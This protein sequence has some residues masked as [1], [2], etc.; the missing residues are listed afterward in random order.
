MAE[1]QPAKAI[2]LAEELSY[3]PHDTDHVH[4]AAAELRRIYAMNEEL[5]GALKAA[6]PSVERDPT[7]YKS[8]TIKRCV[9]A[10]AKAG[11]KQ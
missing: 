5:V 9:E 1:K 8:E 10:I 7:G 2:L 6:I 4:S 11:G 3:F